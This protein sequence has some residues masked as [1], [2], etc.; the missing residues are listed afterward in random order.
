MPEFT[1]IAN[2]RDALITAYDHREPDAAG[3]SVPNDKM[4][5]FNE[6]WKKIGEEEIEVEVEPLPLEQFDF[7]DNSPGVLSAGELAVLG[8]LVKGD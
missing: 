5:E 8:D 6:A 1:T 3:F 7:G 2:Q 4:P